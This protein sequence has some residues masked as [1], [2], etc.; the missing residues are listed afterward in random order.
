MLC[1]L[2]TI[3]HQIWVKKALGKLHDAYVQS[4]NN[5][6]GK[7]QRI[8]DLSS[9]ETTTK[10]FLGFNLSVPHSD[11]VNLLWSDK[12]RHKIEA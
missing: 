10:H 1:G 12:L 2:C 6:D 9:S 8:S 4:I 7:R 11:H 5:D 3:M